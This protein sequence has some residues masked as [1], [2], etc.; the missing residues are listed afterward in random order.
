[1]WH[2]SP[3]QR[4]GATYAQPNAACILML[5]RDERPIEDPGLPWLVCV[6]TWLPWSS[7]IQESRNLG[8]HC[9]SL[10]ERSSTVASVRHQTDQGET[11]T[12]KAWLR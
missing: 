8:G 5:N 10:G 3:C 1:V 9:V 2:G 11:H 12:V 6:R 4:E 7:P